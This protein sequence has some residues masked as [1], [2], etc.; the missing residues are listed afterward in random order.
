MT[1]KPFSPSTN[2]P[3]KVE[4][5]YMQMILTKITCK[6]PQPSQ[7]FKYSFSVHKG[8][9]RSISQAT[10]NYKQQKR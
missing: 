8:I 1:D 10:G 2:T 6:L 9:H 4:N 3:F 5:Y 7:D